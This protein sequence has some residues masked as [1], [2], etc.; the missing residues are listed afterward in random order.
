MKEFK[1]PGPDDLH[2]RILTGLDGSLC[3]LFEKSGELVK[4]QMTGEEQRALC[5]QRG[6]EGSCR[7]SNIDTEKINATHRDFHLKS[8]Q[9]N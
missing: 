8:L 3:I 7:K 9:I 1:F 4:C 6:K 5:H 2:W